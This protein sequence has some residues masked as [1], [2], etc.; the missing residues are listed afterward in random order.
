[1][2]CMPKL[3][4]VEIAFGVLVDPPK[5]A[6]GHY[7]RRDYDLPGRCERIKYQRKW[8]A[9]AQHEELDSGTAEG[10]G[11][12]SASAYFYTCYLLNDVE[13]YEN[14]ALRSAISDEVEENLMEL[15]RRF[16]GNGLSRFP[17]ADR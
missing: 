7:R 9:D 13:L 8:L 6:V 1:M 5:L 14:D 12:T 4:S 10:E 3:E 16:G 15:R 2:L 11:D 17:Y